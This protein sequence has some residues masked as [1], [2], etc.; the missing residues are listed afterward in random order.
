MENLE[1]QEA[2]RTLVY[3]VLVLLVFMV[4]LKFWLNYSLSKRLRHAVQSE[5]QPEPEKH[6]SNDVETFC[7]E[8]KVRNFSQKSDVCITQTD[9]V[10]V[11]F[12]GRL[13]RTEEDL[14]TL[15][16]EWKHLGGLNMTPQQEIRY[17]SLSCILTVYDK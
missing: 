3:V 17:A 12:D 16:Q 10:M 15:R 2:A 8:G 14:A 5:T 7:P 1:V 6:F 9:A 13:P 11:W 4:V